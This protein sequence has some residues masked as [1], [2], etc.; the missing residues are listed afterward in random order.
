[1]Y[2]RIN[3]QQINSDA[4]MIAIKIRQGKAILEIFS[5]VNRISKKDLLGA[6]QISCDQLKG[7]GQH[8]IT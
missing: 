7:R 8:M 3:G 1:M 2:I 5:M 4:L 6:V